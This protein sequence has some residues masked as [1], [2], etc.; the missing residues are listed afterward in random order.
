MIELP[1]WIVRTVRVG[2]VAL[3]FALA[4]PAGDDVLLRAI[5][6]ADRTLRRT[7]HGDAP[8]ATPA[9][10]IVRLASASRWRELPTTRDGA[11]PTST[12]DPM[13]MREVVLEDWRGA[14]AI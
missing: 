14:E 11:L 10:T 3:I 9:A 2:T 4:V 13:P 1:L 7:Q 5:S 8:R 12:H 6:P